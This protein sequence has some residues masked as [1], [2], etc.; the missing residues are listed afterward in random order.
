[1]RNQTNL[2]WHTYSKRFKE[3]LP[4][5]ELIHGPWHATPVQF[6][7]Q[8]CNGL[9]A[10]IVH[11]INQ[12]KRRCFVVTKTC[13]FVQ[14]L[15][16]WPF[17]GNFLNIKSENSGSMQVKCT[18]HRR[19]AYFWSLNTEISILAITQEAEFHLNYIVCFKNILMAPYFKTLRQQMMH[20][21]QPRVLKSPATYSV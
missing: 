11:T 3:S 18:C 8:F 16:H 20:C 17:T 13:N 15:Q 6:W 7:R 4:F 1:M 14:L 2:S 19:D 21:K 10:I 9:P 5:N 12:I